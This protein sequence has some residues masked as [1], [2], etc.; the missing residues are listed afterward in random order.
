MPDLQVSFDQ[1]YRTKSEK[2]KLQTDKTINAHLVSH[3]ETPNLNHRTFVKHVLV[4]SIFFG[5][6]KRHK[7][8]FLHLAPNP[9]CN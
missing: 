9:P 8:I 2:Q 4:V 1:E 7:L 5:P 3:S 6:E